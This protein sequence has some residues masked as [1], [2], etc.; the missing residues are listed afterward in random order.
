M[1]RVGEARGGGEGAARGYGRSRVSV[2]SE[3]HPRLPGTLFVASTHGSGSK[4]AKGRGK[5]DPGAYRGRGRGVGGIRGRGACRGN[6][7]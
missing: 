6:T 7:P 2:G 3:D 4:R 1:A 5:E